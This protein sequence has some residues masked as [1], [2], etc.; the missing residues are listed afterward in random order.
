MISGNSK[1][2]VNRKISVN[3]AS[4]INSYQES[5]F[6]KKNLTGEISHKTE[7]NRQNSSGN[8]LSMNMRKFNYNSKTGVIKVVINDGKEFGKIVFTNLFAREA[9]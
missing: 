3:S 6:R 2:S 7:Q 9:I 8:Y 1:T 5:R 4:S